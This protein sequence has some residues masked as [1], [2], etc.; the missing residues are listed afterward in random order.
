MNQHVDTPNSLN[1]VNDVIRQLSAQE[2]ARV[3][4]IAGL[5]RAM[6]NDNDGNEVELAMTLV[7]AELSASANSAVS[8]QVTSEA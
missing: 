7:L 4:C 1:E 5:F 2:K 8:P 3:Y 6:V